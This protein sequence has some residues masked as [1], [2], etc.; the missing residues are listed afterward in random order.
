MNPRGQ[1]QFRFR[2]RRGRARY[3]AYLRRHGLD[4][5]PGHGLLTLR[6]G[7]R[8]LA[9]LPLIAVLI[10][11]LTQYI[12]FADLGKSIGVVQSFGGASGALGTTLSVSPTSDTSAGDL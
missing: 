2:R 12:R 9:L 11:P 10:L 8:G 7:R 1:F 3:A 6:A 5:R 4:R